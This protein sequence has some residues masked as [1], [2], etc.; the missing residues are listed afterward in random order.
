MFKHQKEGV[1]WLFV[2]HQQNKGCVLAD[3]KLIDL[4]LKSILKYFQLL[5]K[6]RYGFG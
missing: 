2:I 1:K 6:Y 3:G 5:L 4:F